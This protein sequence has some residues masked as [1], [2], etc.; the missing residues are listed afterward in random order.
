MS[1]KGF[2]KLLTGVALGAGLGILFAPKNGKET[3]KELKLKLDEMLAKV[4]EVDVNEVKETIENKIYQIKEEIES[5]DKEKVVEIAKKKAKDVQDMAEELV[6]YAIE[7][8]TPVLEK[9][10]DSIRSKAV[11]VTKEILNKLEKEKKEK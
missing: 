8:G 9:T 10:A 6:E 7:K 3:R 1:K 4:K 2:G 5:L 11:D